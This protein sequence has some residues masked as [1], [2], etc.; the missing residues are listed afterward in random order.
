MTGYTQPADLE[1]GMTQEILTVISGSPLKTLVKELSDLLEK[2][3]DAT[4]AVPDV[5][6]VDGLLTVAWRDDP[7]RA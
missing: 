3:P 5:D 1:A 2:H 6:Y 4:V 7:P